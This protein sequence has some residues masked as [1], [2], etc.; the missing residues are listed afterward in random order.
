MSN[1][2]FDVLG[3]ERARPK[4]RL[5]GGDV[6]AKKTCKKMTAE[7]PE[8]KPVKLLIITLT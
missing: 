6:R 3:L 8:I 2:Q 5:R 1:D 7:V 4:R